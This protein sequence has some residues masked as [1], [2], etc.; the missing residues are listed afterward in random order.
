[1]LSERMTK[2]ATFARA[3]HRIVHSLLR[4]RGRRPACAH[5]ASRKV[6]DSPYAELS[7]ESL[8]YVN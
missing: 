3:S 2:D 1:M 6:R 7:V 8:L 5:R 4:L